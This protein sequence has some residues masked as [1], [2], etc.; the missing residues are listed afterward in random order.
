MSKGTRVIE[1]HWWVVIGPNE[2]TID[3][4]ALRSTPDE[5]ISDAEEA[6]WEDEEQNRVRVEVPE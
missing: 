3:Y 4:E 6:Y 2:N 5:A 1:G